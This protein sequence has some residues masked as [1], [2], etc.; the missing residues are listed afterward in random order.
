MKF[1]MLMQLRLYSGDFCYI[2]FDILHIR[3]IANANQAALCQ[4]KGPFFG[5][6]RFVKYLLYYRSQSPTKIKKAHHVG[7]V[8]RDGVMR[9]AIYIV[10]LREFT[11]S[12]EACCFQQRIDFRKGIHIMAGDDIVVHHMQSVELKRDA[13]GRQKPYG[14]P[15]RQMQ[16]Y[17]D[18]DGG[19]GIVAIL[20]CA[21]SLN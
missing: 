3:Q 13:A 4:N 15:W 20:F 9:F 6:F 7:S 10:F 18:A 11:H 21:P 5:P 12:S 14:N 1:L 2:I 19:F 16:S 8:M 17:D